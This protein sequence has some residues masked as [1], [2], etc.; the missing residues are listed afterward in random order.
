MIRLK[1]S[2]ENHAPPIQTIQIKRV[3]W[4][5][6]YG[7]RWDGRRF[8]SHRRQASFKICKMPR[9]LKWIIYTNWNYGHNVYYCCVRISYFRWWLA[10][11]RWIIYCFL[12]LGL[13]L[14]LYVSATIMK[15]SLLM[16][17]CDRELRSDDL[18]CEQVA[19]ECDIKILSPT[20]NMLANRGLATC[21]LKLDFMAINQ[22][23][24]FILALLYLP[25]GNI[26][27]LS[28]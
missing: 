16:W 25:K 9:Y 19:C 17:H 1:T 21:N 2:C 4:K 20:T 22:N 10:V 24:P 3:G 26:L 13:N 28:G 14:C 11:H 7:W 23:F 5:Q 18:G 8:L 6:K 12:I 15:G 27:F